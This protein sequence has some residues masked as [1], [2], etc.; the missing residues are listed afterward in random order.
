MSTPISRTAFDP[1]PPHHGEPPQVVLAERRL[2]ARRAERLL[3]LAERLPEM[4]GFLTFNAHLCRAQ[5]RVLGARASRGDFD[6]HSWRLA[7][8]HGVPPLT[9]AALLASLDWR[10]DLDALLDELDLALA[11]EGGRF[12]A[13]RECLAMLVDTPAASRNEIARALLERR[14]LPREHLALAPPIGAALQ[15]AWTRLARTLDP[16]PGRPTGEAEGLCPCCGMP[17]LASLIQLGRERS[18]VR[19]LHCGLCA[20]EWY[21]ERA[22]CSQC[23][24]TAKLDYIG[25]ED[26]DGKSA[27]ALRVECCGTCRGALKLV[28]RERDAAADPLA[29]DLASL[30]LD[31]LIEAEGYGRAGFNPL[32]AFGD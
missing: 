12:A 11:E 5:H 10:D 32:I 17:P 24:D 16:A 2:F 14:G 23:F 1:K 3:Q 25:C 9:P 4:S 22:R 8:E 27:L 21:L 13:Q 31:P 15:V 28:D 20:T 6:A 18:R 19:Y 30:G 26:T 29:E 7:I